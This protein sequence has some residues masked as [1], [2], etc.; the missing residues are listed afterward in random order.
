MR[1]RIRDSCAHASIMLK[2]PTVPNSSIVPSVPLDEASV[3]LGENLSSDPLRIRLRKYRKQFI[4]GMYVTKL[5]VHETT[6]A[7]FERQSGEAFHR[8]DVGRIS[9]TGWGRFVLR[10]SL[11]LSITS[12][13]N[14]KNRQ[15]QLCTE[16]TYG[17]LCIR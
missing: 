16:H 2:R 6:L 3:I 7:R 4:K 11:T 1:K 10:P 5:C 12:L 9:E 17:Q 8:S 14:S 13:S 15:S